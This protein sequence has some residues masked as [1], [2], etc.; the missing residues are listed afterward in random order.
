[1][2]TKRTRH[3]KEEVALTGGGYSSRQL[4]TLMAALLIA[5]VLIPTGASALGSLVTI[6]DATS[7]RRARV[8]VG[9]KLRVGDGTGDL[10]VDG[11]VGTFPELPG[12][13]FQFDITTAVGGSPFLIAGPLAADQQVMVT[14]F[15]QTNITT[16][17]TPK[18]PVLFTQAITGA[19][20]TDVD[21]ATQEHLKILTKAESMGQLVFPQPFV[22]ERPDVGPAGWCLWLASDS[23][24]TWVTGYLP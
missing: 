19:D 14:M 8:D 13:P 15:G 4:V 24:H 16:T 10:S 11:T 1:M 5:V 20:C 12:T 23:T 17:A 2:R 22:I 9:G 21:P 18:K 6:E 3:L 7:T